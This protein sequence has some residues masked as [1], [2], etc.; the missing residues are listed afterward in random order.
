[1]GVGES[2]GG[3]WGGDEGKA[4]GNLDRS[5]SGEMR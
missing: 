2:D 1:M 5:G 3:G 4:G